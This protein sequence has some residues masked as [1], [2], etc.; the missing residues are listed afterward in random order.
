MRSTDHVGAAVAAIRDGGTVV[1]LDDT[2]REDEADLV[3]AAQYATP[4]VVARFLDH[5]S[6]F[7]CVAL[8]PERADALELTPMVTDNGDPHGTA[9]TVSVDVRVGT[10]TGISAADRAATC[11][12]LASDATRPADFAR[13]GHV[14]P[15]RARPGGVRSR[16]GHT[17]AGVDLCRLAGLAPAAVICELVTPDRLDMLRGA[18]AVAF[19]R[20]HGL[21]VITVGALAEHLWAAGPSR[22]VCTGDAP[23][24]TSAGE[25]TA[26]AF[27]D[28]VSGVEHVA[29]VFGDPAAL[30]DGDPVLCRV[31]SECFTGDVLGS[32]RCDCGPQL[33]DALARIAAAG[34]G[35]LVHLRGH[36]GRGIGLGA[37]LRAYRL[38]DEGLDT[39]DANT[40]LGLPVDARDWAAAAAILRDLGVT[41]VDLITNNPAKMTGLRAHGV[42][43]RDRV[44]S[45][46]Q[47][48]EDSVGYLASK[49]DRLGH[50]LGPVPA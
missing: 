48:S 21:P 46:P 50:L 25:C 12:A 20:Q 49:R 15:L 13:P 37:K 24:T 31:H 27:A 7:L 3:V 5:T 38:Q 1:V 42:D 41:E 4:Q 30:A 6:G 35:V 16:R 45:H 28:R 36:E 10:T 43:V 26:V 9:F 47:A 33:H 44:P 17:E 32:A 34:R 2:D 22:V 23:I 29:L 19:A 14:L 8:A 39:V 40:A 11:R 18:D